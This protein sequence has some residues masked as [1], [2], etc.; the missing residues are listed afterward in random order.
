MSPVPKR[1]GAVVP[2]P[3]VATGNPAMR[4]SSS[5]AAPGIAVGPLPNTTGFSGVGWDPEKPVMGPRLPALT[6]M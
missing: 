4:A 2:P 3:P 1:P 6:D 5:R